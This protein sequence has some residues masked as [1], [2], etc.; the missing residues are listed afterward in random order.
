M[1]LKTKFY[2]MLK[3][4]LIGSFI[5]LSF[6]FNWAQQTQKQLDQVIKEWAAP[7]EF[8]DHVI[9]SATADP[10]QSVGVNWRTHATNTKGYIEIGI[11]GPGPDFRDNIKTFPAKRT[12]INSAK[13]SKD[14]FESSFFEVQLEKLKPNTQYAYR[15]GNDLFKSEWHQFTTASNQPSPLSF[16]YVGDAQNYI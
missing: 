12:L 10:T 15:V 2:C 7:N 16:L 1:I 3:K 14:G 11:A 9:L 5:L 13:A 8:P 4:L 6:Q